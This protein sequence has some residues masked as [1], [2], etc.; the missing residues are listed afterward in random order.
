MHHN[1]CLSRTHVPDGHLE[2]QQTAR[3]GAAKPKRAVAARN[4]LHAPA[5]RGRMLRCLEHSSDLAG[6]HAPH[7]CRASPPAPAS[8][9]SARPSPVAACLRQ[10]GRA[11]V[12]R[13]AL[14]HPGPPRHHRNR[15]HAITA[16]RDATTA[17][18]GS[19]L[20]H[21]RA[22]SSPQLPPR[23][24]PGRRLQRRGVGPSGGALRGPAR[25]IR[26]RLPRG[27]ARTRSTGRPGGELEQSRRQCSGSW[28]TRKSAGT[29]AGARGT[30]G[31]G[32]TRQ[33][34]YRRLEYGRLGQP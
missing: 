23:R 18:D 9:P 13:P 20:H 8:A 29:A 28:S 33:L 16:T 26:L 7:P 1:P 3:Y 22:M 12:P 25:N 5:W 14:H 19:T 6:A 30:S 21:Q 11:P 15:A 27:P 32:Q 24:V 10:P 2:P 17:C 31:R 34:G 4:T